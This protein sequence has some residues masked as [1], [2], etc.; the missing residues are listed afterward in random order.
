MALRFVSAGSTPATLAPRSTVRLW[1]FRAVALLGVPALLLVALELGLRV[2]GYGRPASFL[3]PDSQPGFYRSN[4]EYVGL[5]MPASFDLRPLNFRVAKQKP[6]GTLRV[7][8]LG[9]SAAQGIPAPAFGFVP[10]LR[11]QLRARYPGRE[12]EVLNTAI[13]A[14]NSHVVHQIARDVA[15]FAPDLFV[16]YLGNNEVVGPYGPGCSYLSEAPPLPVIRASVAVRSTRTGQLLAAALARFSRRT[17]PAEWGGM[18][19][20]VE[21][22]VTGDDPRLETVYRNFEANLRDIVRVAE[23]AG[24][25]VLLSTVVANLKDCPPLL[26]RHRPGLAGDELARWQAAHDRGRIAWR[27]DDPATA[28]PHLEEARRLDPQYADTL[29][30]LGDLELR[31][32]NIAAARRLFVEALRWDA[33]RFRPDPRINEIIRRIAADHPAARLVDTARLLGADPA[34]GAPIAGRE[35]L[36]EHVHFDWEGNYRVARA[37]A[38]GSEDLLGPAPAGA[39]AWLDSAATAAAVGYT[40]RERAGVLQKIGPLIQSPPFPNQLTYTED[41]ARFARESTQARAAARDPVV[42]QRAREAIAAAIARDPGNP[43]LAKIED[44]IAD[45]LGD[46]PAALAA[47]ERARRLQPDNY[48]VVGNVAIKLARLGR[49]TEAETLLHDM[50]ARSPVSEQIALLPAF[51]DLHARLKAPEKHRALLERLHSMRPG[52]TNLLLARARWAESQGDTAAAERDLRAILARDPGQQMALEA[53]VGL[54][55]RTN[56]A[57]AEQVTLDFADRQTRNHANNLRAALLAERRNDTE[58][59]IRFLR[60]AERSGPVPAG[61]QIRLA[62]LLIERNQP[63][64]ALGHLAEA[65]RIALAEGDTETRAAVEQ[66]IRQMRGGGP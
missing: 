58:A 48:A 28:R 22:A 21:Q 9:E 14:I 32:G 60:A 40:G 12:I 33:L 17:Q 65:R 46:L 39:P 42:L 24:A 13:V 43:F 25:K 4:Q 41:M 62:R 34:S 31:A 2:T 35:L 19:M 5:F 47:A 37:L 3:V 23:D 49:L 6:P 18:G 64:D 59:Q 52:D 38:E 8:V 66:Y 1:I 26:S 7:V 45:D 10:Q 51:A 57:A 61:L 44:E 20:F 15:D 16:I 63:I 29:F 30:M 53:L 55:A 50:A 27:L 54:L 11:A 56:P 36:F